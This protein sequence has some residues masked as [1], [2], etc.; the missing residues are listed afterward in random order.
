VF[1]G[2]PLVTEQLAGERL[3]KTI[4]LGVL[5]PD[6]I[7]SSAYGTEQILNQM[8]PYIGLAAFALVVPI[9]F[10]IIGVLLFVSISYFDVIKYYTAAGGS[11]VVARENFGPRIA[12]I[13]AV[14]LLIDYTVTVAVQCSAGT[15]ALTS[16]VPSLTPYTL[17]ITVGVVLILLFGNLRGLREAGSYFAVPTYLYIVLMI[18]T[19]VIG[20]YKKL[21]GTLVHI[22]TPSNTVLGYTLGHKGSGILMG[23]AFVTLLRA[24]ANGGSSLTGL[25]AI[26][27]GVASFK[28][29]ESHNARTT[30]IVMATVLGF[31]LLGTTLLASWMHAIPY[32]AGTPTVVSQEVLYIFGSHGFGHFVFYAVQFATLLILYTGGNTSFNGFPFLANYVATDKY[33][34]RQLTKRGHRLAFSNGI[35]L[36]GAIALTLIIVFDAQVNALIALYAIGVFTGFTMAG[37][38]MVKRHL[39]EKT[40]KWR[41]GIVANGVSATVTSIVVLVFLFAKF[42][43]GAWIIAVVGPIMYLALIQFNKQYRREQKAFE[44]LDEAKKHVDI[45]MNRVVVFVDQYDLATERALLYCQTLS[46]YSLRAVHF[47]IDPAVTREL[48]ER[49]GRA[50]SASSQIPLEIVECEDRRVDRAALEL[51]ADVVRDPQV[52]CMVVLPRRGFVS[53]LQRLLHDRTADDIASAVTHVPRTS[54]T[55]IPYRAA[56]HRLAEGDLAESPMSDDVS[57]GGIREDAHLEAD[58]KLAERSGGTVP[59][60]GVT[61]R[62]IVDVAGRVRAMTISHENGGNELRCVIADNSGSI[63]LVFQG[64]D[65]VPGIERGTRLLV[66]GTVMSQRREAVILN[67]QYEIV[68]SP[69]S[70]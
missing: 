54:A 21:N 58:V 18:V 15:A 30:L 9:M 3:T 55:I 50:G 68:A 46:S 1:L 35:L 66:K 34:P 59:I 57:R 64:R 62:Q 42:T 41:F 5:S 60:G 12:Q 43:E 10:V 4:A 25:E 52:F 7:S 14:A 61:E 28:K 22:A 70:D 33:L 51:V 20:F 65:A 31:L 17:A 13:A 24:Y 44:V 53:R 26:S 2:K 39:R 32:E 27:N 37:L 19:I 11:Y 16:A 23:L 38:G 45:R 36:L 69:Q 48:E 63:T 29:P 6:C 8:T 47:D 56:R 40:G 67:P 49:W